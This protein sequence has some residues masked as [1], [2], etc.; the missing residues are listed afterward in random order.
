MLCAAA[1]GCALDTLGY[2]SQ[3]TE[4]S[5]KAQQNKLEDDRIEDKHPVF[6]PGLATIESF[7]GCDIALNKSGSVTKLGVAAYEFA[8]NHLFL[9]GMQF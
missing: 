4:T 6:D 7:D 8:A 5:I 9:I 3:V 1:G 2:E